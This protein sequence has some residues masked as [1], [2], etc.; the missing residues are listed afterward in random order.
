MSERA[1]FLLATLCG[2]VLAAGVHLAIVLGS[3]AY[4][5]KDAFSRLA[6]TLAAEQTTLIS[7]TGGGGTWLPQVETLKMPR[8]LRWSLS[9][10]LY[11]SVNVTASRPVQLDI[12]DALREKILDW[13]RYDA[14]LVERARAHLARRI[15]AYRGDFARDLS[16]FRQLNSQFQRGA[17][18]EELR[19]VERD[20]IA[21]SANQAG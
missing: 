17:P 16:L 21:S 10:L 14:R 4:A 18:I 6:A 5:R 12:S 1:R 2:L 15:A 11:T 19:R 20:A 8:D 3:P 9:D 7:P 13:N